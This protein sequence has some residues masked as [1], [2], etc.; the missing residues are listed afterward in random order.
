VSA[1][2]V[3]L[4]L[5]LDAER[6]GAPTVGMTVT[7][8]E[9]T[10]TPDELRS[11]IKQVFKAVRRR[12]P[13]VEYC[14][15][16]E[17]TSGTAA[18]SG[19]RRRVHVHFLVKGLEA[20]SCAEAEQLLRRVWQ[21]RTGA[22]RVEVRELRSAGGATA[23]LA[24]HHRKRS[25]GPPPGLRGFRRLRSSQGYFG[26]PAREL[27]QEARELLADKRF[28]LTVERR[29]DEQLIEAGVGTREMV[30]LPDGGERELSVYRSGASDI[31]DEVLEEELERA[32]ERRELDKPVLV[33]VR[34]RDVVDELTG[35][36]RRELV[37]VLD[38]VG[39]GPLDGDYRRKP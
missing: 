32:L 24:L 12:W 9:A 11:A 27:R 33:R 14:A 35:E 38:R 21:G 22:H 36:T 34:Q 31:W 1:L 2:E 19:G 37:E 18:R 6:H 39:P 15:F 7:T 20:K 30:E 23:Y 10:T 16:V 25:Q 5:K 13:K 29:V 4:M 26:R 17:W 8:V 28:R 3:E